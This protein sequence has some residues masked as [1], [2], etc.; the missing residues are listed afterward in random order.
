E[1]DPHI[2]RTAVFFAD[3]RD[4]A[5]GVVFRDQ[6]VS[7]AL[8][9]FRPRALWFVF[10]ALEST[11]PNDPSRSPPPPASPPL[12]GQ[13]LICTIFLPSGTNRSSTRKSPFAS[14]AIAC[15]G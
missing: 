8:F 12:A 4:A 6:L 1:G 15:V 13:A 5:V 7:R 2:Q 9:Y 14:I 10:H 3:P 11:S